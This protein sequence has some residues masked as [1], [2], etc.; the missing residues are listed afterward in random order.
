MK[1]LEGGGK[2]RARADKRS[3]RG[4]RE[5]I[6]GVFLGGEGQKNE[7]NLKKIAKCKAIFYYVKYWLVGNYGFLLYYCSSF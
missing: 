6:S 2:A 3:G 5:G 4:S 7:K 1:F